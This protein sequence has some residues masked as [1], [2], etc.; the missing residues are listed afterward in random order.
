MKKLKVDLKNCYGIRE[1][2]HEFDFSSGTPEKPIAKAYA[3]YAPNGVMKS[4]FTKTFEMLSK[5]DLPREE[6]YNR[7]S[8]YNVEADG[9]TLPKDGT[10]QYL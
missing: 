4:S 6:R 8:A 1:L 5:G 7:A 10:C 2:R 9:V 3:I